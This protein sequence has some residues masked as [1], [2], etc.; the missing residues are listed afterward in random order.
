LAD[1]EAEPRSSVF[2]SDG[3]INRNGNLISIDQAG[4][5]GSSR[6]H[7]VDLREVLEEAMTF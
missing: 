1:G 4:E 3:L 5:K 7:F 2:S 6:M